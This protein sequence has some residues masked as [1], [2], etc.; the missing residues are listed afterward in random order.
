VEETAEEKARQERIKK[1][2]EIKEA[3][4]ICDEEL[5]GE[6]VPLGNFRTSEEIDL[7]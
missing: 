2:N 7:L 5:T 1:W 3:I 4:L 6:P